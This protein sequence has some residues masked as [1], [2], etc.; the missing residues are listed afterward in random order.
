MYLT[1][2]HD[3]IKHKYIIEL[4]KIEV[5]AFGF[6]T[7]LKIQ[8]FFLIIFLVPILSENVTSEYNRYMLYTI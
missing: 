2:P 8:I 6:F 3:V 4:Y 7:S 5:G 1:L